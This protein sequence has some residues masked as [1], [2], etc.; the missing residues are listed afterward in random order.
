MIYR[1]IQRAIYL[2]AV[3]AVAT[4]SVR[5]AQTG[6]AVTVSLSGS[7]AMSNFTR[8]AYFTLLNPGGSITLNAG[9]GGAPTIFKATAGSTTAVQLATNNF[10]TGFSGNPSSGLPL[11]FDDPAVNA[12]QYRA[13][14]VEWHEQ[15]SVEGILELINDQIGTVASV[16]ASNRNP[17]SS[18]RVW[19][20]TGSF[21]VAPGSSNGL[22]IAS[23]SYSNSSFNTSGLNLEG[24][25][26][27]VQMAIS[28]VNARQGFAI[29]G[30]PAFTRAP[31]Q[32]GYGMGN[33]ALPLGSTIQGLGVA[34]TRKQMNDASIANMSTDKVDPGT[35][36]N[37][38]S[39]AW[40]SAGIDNLENKTVAITATLAVANPGT[41]LRRL[42]RTDAQWLQTTGRLQNG[43]DFNMVTRDAYSGTLNVFANNTGVDPSWVVGENDDG[44]GN[45]ATG[46]TTQVA[47]GP[48]IKFSGKTSG[49]SGLR[50]TVQNSRMAIGHLSMSDA[51]ASAT[52]GASRP[53]RALAYRD[54]NDDLA[55][56]SNATIESG[57]TDPV[58]GAFVQ[59]SA[60]SIV[61]GSYV[62]YQNQ[63]YVTVKR[64][65]AVQYGQD[66]IKGDNAGDDVRDL[67]ANILESV[68]S[69]PPSSTGS[70][71]DGLVN[72]S[73][74]LP[75][76]MA[77]KKDT[78]GLNRSVA[79]P[80]YNSTLSSQFLGSPSLTSKFNPADASSVTSG[81]TSRYGDV[82]PSGGQGSIVISSQN[83]LFGNFRQN[84]VRDFAAV[85]AAQAAQAA[86]AGGTLGVDMFSG[87]AGSNVAAV[88][89]VS[90]VL[91]AMNSGAGVT[92]G[93]LIVMGDFN[94]DG[95]FD[96]RDLYHM[97]RGASL[98]DSTSTD[99]LTA[100]SGADFGDQ[101]R[102]GVLRKNAALD[103]M[104]G[105]ATA[106]QRIE[107]SA[108]VANDPTG[109]N[110]FSKADVNRDGLV[111]RADA[112]IVD[113]AIGLDYRN[114]NDQLGAVIATN[115]TLFD[116]KDI[117]GNAT[118][119]TAR[120]ISLVDVELNDT[121]DITYGATS[122]WSI[123]RSAV[124][125]ELVGG[126]ANFDG[127]VDSLDFG[128]LVAN[129]GDTGKKWSQGDF[130][131]VDGKVNTLDFNVLAAN[132]G[133]APGATLGSVVPEPASISLMIVAA[134]AS[135]RRRR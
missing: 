87:A 122:D 127:K 74:I 82:T 16:A 66:L 77:V 75:Q 53:L 80:G 134:S 54:D 5:A 97:A 90:T 26:N 126:D 104:A 79:N 121:G 78:D 73:F 57:F 94:S 17:L 39:G 65:D 113:A 98:A 11:G 100:A 15:G 124:G 81:A 101:I 25:Q 45:L 92:K 20:N 32:A 23:S 105:V 46:G 99:Q 114:I 84:G 7:T 131:G 18:N 109:S 38:G 40:N 133:A 10:L 27:R 43:A 89:G 24:G 19:V 2:A 44:N 3:A 67:R 70:P 120:S 61:D 63:T 130:D 71:A 86:L 118:T 48:G 64:P 35:G 12:A 14:R 93:D 125:T 135:L 49:G 31:G 88:S 129:F 52:N 62:I 55:N 112:Q 33:P 108:S 69:F 85:K 13:M 47:I 29:S 51:I 123:I 28:D 50:P 9:P 37:F 21:S 111:N 56:G 83:Y 76:F 1:S 8:S 110:A 128:T 58:S 116:G 103:Y 115:G 132:F 6:D 22:S 36:S 106:Q 30:A 119:E 96:G 107:A 95:K 60:N 117:N 59:P 72:N 68:N 4:G 91:A 34:N 102:K 42:N 41:G